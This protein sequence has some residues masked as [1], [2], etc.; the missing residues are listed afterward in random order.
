MALA[1]ADDL[2]DIF[3]GGA[4][5]MPSPRAAGARSRCEA[6]GTPCDSCDFCDSQAL[7]R[8]LGPVQGLRPAATDCDSTGPGPVQSQKIAANR[9]RVNGPESEQ[10]RDESQKSRKSQRQHSES[11]ATAGPAPAAL[12]LVAWTDADIARFTLRRNRLLRWGWAEH[13]AEAVAERL[14][15]RDRDADER[16][17][18]ADC[19]HY[20]PHRC[21]NH[22]RAGLCSPSLPADLA[23]LLQRCDG[24][25]GLP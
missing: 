8:V 22:A 19:R 23:R 15:K 21:G 4:L 18:C 11:A 14:V 24:F 7:A 17:N 1:E 2:T 13:D 3:F 25:S 16:V 10:R 6:Q 20:R 12:A 5:R 9:N